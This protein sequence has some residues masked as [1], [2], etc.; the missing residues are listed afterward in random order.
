MKHSVFRL[1]FSALLAL[2]APL[3]V[4]G[5]KSAHPQHGIN[6]LRMNDGTSHK[7]VVK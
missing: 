4:M 1:L 5:L 6:I 2:L 3:A 7:V